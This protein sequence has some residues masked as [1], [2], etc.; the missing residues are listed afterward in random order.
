VETALVDI[1]ANPVL[2]ATEAKSAKQR[3]QEWRDGLGPNTGRAYFR[4]LADFA[5]HLH[6]FHGKR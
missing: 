6:C 5:A 4:D 2:S 1:V 3:L